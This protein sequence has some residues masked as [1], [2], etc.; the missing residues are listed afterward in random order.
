MAKD[1]I[2]V[3]IIQNYVIAVYIHS[4]K[5]IYGALRKHDCVSV[6]TYDLFGCKHHHMCILGRFHCSVICIYVMV[7][8]S[9]P[10]KKNGGKK[11]DTC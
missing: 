6:L 4:N 2:S 3:C 5:M 1:R 8:S 7:E 11:C 9:Q 10:E